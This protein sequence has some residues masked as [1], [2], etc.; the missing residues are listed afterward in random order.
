M[1]E[2]GVVQTVVVVEGFVP[3][4]PPP[5]FKPL[6]A[7]WLS[8][9][10]PGHKCKVSKSPLCCDSLQGEGENLT[11]HKSF[12]WLGDKREKSSLLAQFSR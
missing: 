5:P 7:V 6:F 10:V 12:F 1:P 2:S 4:T 3:K 11:P 9:F 8:S